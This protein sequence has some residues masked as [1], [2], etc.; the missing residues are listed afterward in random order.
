M[1]FISFTGA[2]ICGRNPELPSPA[3]LEDFCRQAQNNGAGTIYYYYL[4][5]KL[6]LPYR[7][8]FRNAWQSDCIYMMKQEMG[9]QTICRKLESE[10]IRFAP[11]KGADLSFSVY[12]D[13]A[14]RTFCDWDI[15][16][17]PDDCE[18]AQELLNQD[19][20][21]PKYVYDGRHYGHHYHARSKGEFHLEPHWTL[22]SFRDVAP[23]DFW[24]YIKPAA[25]NSSRHRL[26]PE[27]NIIMLM[28][29]A[30]SQFYTHL[31]WLRLFTDLS[32]S[33]R[34]T[35]P[36]MELLSSMAKQWNFPNPR[37]FLGA[38][39]EFFCEP[40][41]RNPEKSAVWRD[42]FLSQE[43]FA[44]AQ[45]AEWEMNAPEAY[46]L[47]WFGKNIASFWRRVLSNRQQTGENIFAVLCTEVKLKLTGL[48]R[49]TLKRNPQIRRRRNQTAQAESDW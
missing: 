2:L 39:P 47:S 23:A 1:D 46:S 24:Q 20:W 34:Q 44:S 4:K 48:F 16:L 25:E 42:I 11:F 49:F 19:G 35:P 41:T 27:L 6:P 10:K 22:P 43:N 38:F 14:L 40:I 37:N 12:P 45:D 7:D 33:V 30:S 3:E 29:H 15:L 17:H 5:D 18:K 21:L 13:P 28:R 9:F 26:S 32:F 36:D 31:H 8:T